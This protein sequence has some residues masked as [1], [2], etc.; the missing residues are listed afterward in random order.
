MTSRDKLKPEDIAQLEEKCQRMIYEKED[1]FVSVESK[2]KQEDERI[3]SLE[4]E[5]LEIE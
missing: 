5:L 4:Q 3:N 1:K 2:L